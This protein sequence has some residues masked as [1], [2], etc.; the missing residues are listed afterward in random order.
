MTADFL[1]VGRELF[2]HKHKINKFTVKKKFL[3]LIIALSKKGK[4]SKRK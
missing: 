4:F 1:S 2:K 3:I